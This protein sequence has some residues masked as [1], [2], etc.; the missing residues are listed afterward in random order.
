MAKRLVGLKLEI[1][2]KS[3]RNL[4]REVTFKKNRALFQ[5]SE[6]LRE[7]KAVA[8]LVLFPPI[9]TA[10]ITLNIPLEPYPK[11]KILNPLGED[12]ECPSATIL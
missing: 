11:P 8:W 12:P 9:P 1:L 7:P 4:P 2:R 3:L 10:K 5:L 6:T